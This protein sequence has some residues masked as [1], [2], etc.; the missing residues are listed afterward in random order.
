MSIREKFKGYLKPFYKN[1][2]IGKYITEK[3]KFW[4]LSLDG[5]IVPDEKVLN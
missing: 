4:I 2:D 1:K 5:K 3:N